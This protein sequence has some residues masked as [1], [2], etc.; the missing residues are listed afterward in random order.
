MISKRYP[1]N[2]LIKPGDVK[3][4]RDDFKV[5]CVFNCGVTRFEGD[6]LLLLRV[7]EVP[8]NDNPDVYLTPVYDSEKGKI[9][10]R[11][12]DKNDKSIDFSDSRFV[13]TPNERFLTSISHFRIARSSDGICFT[14]EKTPAMTPANEYEMFGIE[15]P[16]ITC[17]NGIYFINYSCCA[18]LGITTCL[19]STRDFM[20]FERHGVIFT[21]D[22]KDVAIFPEK[23][24]GKY[25]AFS[26]PASDEYEK[27]ELW[28]AESPD[29]VCW[30][31]HKRIMQVNPD[32]WEN[33]RIGCGAVPIL[34][35]RG[36]LEIYHAADARNR[37]CLGAALLD[38]E[39]PWLVLARTPK[40]I[41]EPE[42]PYE[43]E[44]F[45][46]NV[47]F[48]CG[49]LYEEGKVKLYY[50]A[51]DTCIA[52]AEIKINHIFDSLE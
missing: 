7:A 30:G 17:I 13:L 31:N 6:I 18:P 43:K 28:I 21:P 48:T 27:R 29:L 24:D 51:A 20:T 36:W 40:P 34:T 41:L 3:P 32:G 52:C 4:S 45:F 16:R 5:V 11:P 39:K 12:F 2:P 33:G 49:A 38:T 15:D 50:G 46:G 1:Q 26:R 22:N 10:V 9:V 14:I 8:R 23:I 25:Y 42:E 35:D 47:V 37:Y 19:A 44:G